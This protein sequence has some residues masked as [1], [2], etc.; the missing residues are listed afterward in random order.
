MEIVKR[1]ICEYALLANNI[2]FVDG[3][4]RTGKSMLNLLIASLDRVSHPQFIEPLEQ[5]MPMYKTGHVDLNAISSFMRLHLNERIYNYQLSRNL[6]FRLDD[7]T[8]I[9]NSSNSKE[10]IRNLS[11][12]DGD[13]VVKN[14]GLS[15]VIYQFQTH[16]ILTHY[17]TYLKLGLNTKLI[18][19]IRNP[20]DTIHSWFKRGWGKRFDSADPRSG[21]CLFRYK[22]RTIP[23]YVVGSEDRYLELNEMEKCVFMHNKLINES[24]KQY[25][26]LTKQQKSSILLIK[27]EDCLVSPTAV[28]DRISFFLKTNPTDTT[29][30]AYSDARVPRE[31]NDNDRSIKLSDI[32]DNVN[33]ELYEEVVILTSLYEQFSYGME[34]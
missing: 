6:N 23:H 15:D 3:V 34:G 24:I 25:E 2:V 8:S 11:K 20:I 5:L 10:F 29:H 9:H 7:L 31:I 18:E 12:T 21:T 27:F 14:L 32:K 30:K 17:D 22:N 19:I 16:D 26:L 28:I 4:T 13:D 33:D 1:E